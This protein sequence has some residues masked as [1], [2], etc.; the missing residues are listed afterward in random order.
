MRR[1]KILNYNEFL[2]EG[3]QGAD[4]SL[5][6]YICKRFGISKYSTIMQDYLNT[7]DEGVERWDVDGIE[8]LTKLYPD[9][10]VVYKI[11]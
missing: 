9:A 1:S 5:E 10:T 2:K 7:N 6:E 3:F 11:V 8:I 4:N